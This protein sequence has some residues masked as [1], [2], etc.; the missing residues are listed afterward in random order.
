VKRAALAQP[1]DGLRALHDGI[2]AYYGATV[3][4]HGANPLGVDWSCRATQNLRFVQLLRV[5]DFAAPFSLNDVGCG[6]GALIDFIAER[7]PAAAIDYLGIDLSPAMVRHGRRL[8]RKLANHAFTVGCR[9]PRVGDY[10]VASGIFNVMLDHPRDGWEAFIAQT[11]CDLHRTSRRAF[12]VNFMAEGPP[13]PKP[14]PLYRTSPEPWLRHCRDQLQCSVE[15]VTGY[16]MREFTLL[17][18]RQ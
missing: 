5:C 12:A 8:H 4:R 9:S 6:Y 15:V 16:G 10:S 1:T 13:E 3:A 14:R 11:L 17:V 18:R 7:Y 2:G